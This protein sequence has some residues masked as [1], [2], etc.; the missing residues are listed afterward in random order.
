M[1]DDAIVKPR[2]LRSTREAA[3]E[4]DEAVDEGGPPQHSDSPTVTS[5]SGRNRLLA[6]VIVEAALRLAAEPAGLDIF[7][8]QRAR[9]VLGVG[10]TLVQLMAAPGERGAPAATKMPVVRNGAGRR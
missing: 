4:L 6:A 2:A 10:Q 5:L 3:Q 8:Q 7:H 1:G 9:P